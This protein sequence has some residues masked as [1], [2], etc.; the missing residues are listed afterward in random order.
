VCTEV[1]NHFAT[2]GIV[3]SAALLI[4]FPPSLSSFPLFSYF[5]PTH[6]FFNA[7]LAT[8]RDCQPLKQHTKPLLLQSTR[9]LFGAVN[10]LRQD[11]NANTSLAC[12]QFLPS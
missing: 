8:E 11:K 6:I 1:L 7:H 4:P 12:L 3:F 5:F 2:R 10:N 9:G